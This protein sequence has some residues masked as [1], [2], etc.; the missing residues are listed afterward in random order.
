MSKNNER[1]SRAYRI[2]CPVCGRVVYPFTVIEYNDVASWW[3]KDRMT[4]TFSAGYRCSNCHVAF[5][6]DTTNTKALDMFY[7]RQYR[8][9]RRQEKRERMLKKLP[10]L[11]N[12]PNL[13]IP[14][15]SFNQEKDCPKCAWWDGRDCTCPD[16]ECREVKR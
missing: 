12:Q 6:I 10:R 5:S 7:R 9:V 14:E 1:W 3:N 13:P 16:D 11:K 4:P 15:L 2:I 8:L